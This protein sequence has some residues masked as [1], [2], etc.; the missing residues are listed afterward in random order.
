VGG[1]DHRVGIGTSTPAEALHVD[2]TVRSTG[3]KLTTGAAD[4]YV[5]TSNYLGEASWEPLSAGGDSDWTVVGDTMYAE[6]SGNVGVGTTSPAEKLEVVGNIRASGDLQASGL[7]VIDGSTV[8]AEIVTSGATGVMTTYGP[9]GN[10]NVSLTAVGSDPDQ[11]YVAVYDDTDTKRA[12]MFVDPATGQGIVTADVKS[13]RTA[14]PA[15]PGKEIWYASLEGPE[16]AAYVRGTARLVDGQATIVLPD[17]FTAV[18]LSEG[19]T[20]QLT[21]LSADSKG[22]AVIE[23]TTSRVVVR[24]LQGGIGNYEFD[25]MVTAVRRGHEDF[26]VIRDR[27]G[28]A[29][30]APQMR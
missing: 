29:T 5:L 11:G 23:K 26:R 30:V 6:V 12:A 13:F 21:P 7:A 28:D 15:R 10:R 4:G 24:E 2:G 17:H 27:A 22:L 20:V 18:V 8:K 9:S 16:A 25:F 14:H 19:M 3:L 1:P